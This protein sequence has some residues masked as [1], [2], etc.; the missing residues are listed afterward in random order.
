VAS[1]VAAG[2]MFWSLI[3]C[4]LGTLARLLPTGLQGEVGRF[5]HW[6]EIAWL[7]LGLAVESPWLGA[8]SLLLCMNGLRRLS[9]GHIGPPFLAVKLFLGL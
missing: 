8:I 9:S 3:L 7:F 4:I 5:Q 1:V 2:S 6:A